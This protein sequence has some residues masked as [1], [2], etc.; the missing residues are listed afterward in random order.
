MSKVSTKFKKDD[1][2]KIQYQGEPEQKSI[3]TIDRFDFY[4]EGIPYW[5]VKER[6]YSIPEQILKL[7]TL[8]K[9]N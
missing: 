2:V 1:K 3:L 8:N 6:D 9:K 4:H 7:F 5:K